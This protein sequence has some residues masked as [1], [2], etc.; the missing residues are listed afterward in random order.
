MSYIHVCITRTL[1]PPPAP[2]VKKCVQVVRAFTFGFVLHGSS[3]HSSR[4][5]PADSFRCRKRGVWLRRH[6]RAA[7][8]RA[9]P[10]PSA[11]GVFFRIPLLSFPP[12][13]ALSF[14]PRLPSIRLFLTSSFS[15]L[16][17]IFFS[18]LSD[19]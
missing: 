19:D 3:S 13:F 14:H 18:F 5:S 6:R 10:K 7:P 12:P 2:R 9:V 1:F 16:F 11:N 15:S 8:T 17:V 4:C